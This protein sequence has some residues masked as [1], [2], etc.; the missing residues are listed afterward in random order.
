MTCSGSLIKFDRI[1]LDTAPT[2][3]TMRMLTLPDFLREFVR[4]VKVIRDKAGN[5]G[6]PQD[7]LTA[8][9]DKIDRLTKFERNMEK[10]EDMLH[11]Q[12]ETEFVVVTIPTEV[13]MQETRRLL[14]SL[15][16]SS[17][18]LRRVLVNQVLPELGSSEEARKTRAEE[19]LSNL[20]KNQ[21]KA[22]SDL[23]NLSISTSVPL[24]CVPFFETEIRNTYGL[25]FVGNLIFSQT[26]NL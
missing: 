20:R 18:F 19:Y 17:V 25:Q 4:K 26:R 6:L 14:A 16:E 8:D 9:G 12:K 13:A 2:G 15:R 22:L 1:V 10:L 7:R 5:I 21:G 23:E 3:H 24:I 11:N